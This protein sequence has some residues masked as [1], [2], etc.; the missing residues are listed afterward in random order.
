MVEDSFWQALGKGLEQAKV[1]AVSF[2]LRVVVHATALSF[3]LL[4]S[5]RWGFS[6]WSYVGL[7]C[8]VP[9]GISPTSTWLLPTLTGAAQ[10]AFLISQGM[11]PGAAVFFGGLQTWA[12]RVFEKKGRVGWEWVMAPIL[13]L[14]VGFLMDLVPWG[15]F[16]AVAAAGAA[17]Q[18]VYGYFRLSPMLRGRFGNVHKALQLRVSDRSLP[19]PLEAPLRRLVG[20]LGAFHTHCKRPD[21]KALPLAQAADDILAQLLRLKSRS[22]PEAWDAAAGKTFV[23][24]GKLNEDLHTLLMALGPLSLED[25]PLD[26]LERFQAS[27][28]E[29]VRKR[30]S[31]P[32]PLQ[33]HLEAIVA[34]AE[35]LIDCIRRDSADLAPGSRFLNRYLPAAHRVVDEYARLSSSGWEQASV[36]TKAEE[37]LARLAKAF[38]SE[39]GRLLENDAMSLGAELKVLDKLLQMDGK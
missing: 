38:H 39:C 33:P 1:A 2:G 9:R 5:A 13:C 3:W 23:A 30:E 28:L 22:R 19:P 32:Q 12:Q 6:F 21:K 15:T 31:L 24:V 8:L 18:T 27:A 25:A 26:P 7:I 4:G 29:L 20:Q 35:R 36:L 16:A 17:V 37:V 10:T 11:P 34:G 14:G